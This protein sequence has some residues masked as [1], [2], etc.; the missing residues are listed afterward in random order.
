M[1]KNEKIKSF[2]NT[3]DISI[4]D[5]PIKG[6]WGLA[7]TWNISYSCIKQNKNLKNIML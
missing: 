1:E 6:I 4:I 3:E 5:T 2:R 7:N